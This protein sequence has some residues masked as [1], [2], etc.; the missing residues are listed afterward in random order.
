MLN[1]CWGPGRILPDE[2]ESVL[3]GSFV[4]GRTGSSN[5][6]GELA[7]GSP[8]FPLHPLQTEH[9]C[10]ALLLCLYLLILS[11]LYSHQ[12]AGTVHTWVTSSRLTPAACSISVSALVPQLGFSKLE[13]DGVLSSTNDISQVS[14]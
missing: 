13:P 9:H 14:V 10:S 6:S 4:W 5:E 11:R 2:R 12:W 3:S 1:L 7:V 8:L